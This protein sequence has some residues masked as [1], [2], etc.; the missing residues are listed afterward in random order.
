M[1]YETKD[2]I[3]ILVLPELTIGCCAITSKVTDKQ[4]ADDFWKMSLLISNQCQINCQKWW[5]DDF[6]KVQ[7]INKSSVQTK[8]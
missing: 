1:F 6:L 8:Q 2:Q 4:T 7:W 5:C 3:K